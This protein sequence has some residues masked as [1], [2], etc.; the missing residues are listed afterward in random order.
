MHILQTEQQIDFVRIIAAGIAQMFG[1]N[2]EP[3]ITTHIDANHYIIEI[4]NG[5]ITNR[6]TGDMSS[7]SAIKKGIRDGFNTD[8]VNYTVKHDNGHLLKC[9]SFHINLDGVTYALGINYD[10]TDFAYTNSIIND[11]IQTKEERDDVFSANPPDM[12]NKMINQCL[13][14]IGKP[15]PMLNKADRMEII[16]QLHERGGFLVHKAAAII[17]DTLNVSKC[18]I[19]NYLKELEHNQKLS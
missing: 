9:S 13:A 2:C 7:I 1:H 16:R 5:H 10:Y 11:F 8:E 15:V 4:N 12:L 19:Y 17:A 14:N 6:Q 18:T 3:L